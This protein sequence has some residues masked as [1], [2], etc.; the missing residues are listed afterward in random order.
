L[1]CLPSPFLSLASAS[2]GGQVFVFMF[3]IIYGLVTLLPA[4]LGIQKALDVEDAPLGSEFPVRNP[5]AWAAPATLAGVVILV[6]S[7]VS[8]AGIA[9]IIGLILFLA[10]AAESGAWG[11]A[12]ARRILR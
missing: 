5:G 3:A 9:V 12:P 4:A 2:W 10:G 6:L 8:G 1:S 7:L 11:Y